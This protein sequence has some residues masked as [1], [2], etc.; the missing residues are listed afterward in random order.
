MPHDP[1]TCFEVEVCQLC[2]AYGDGYA[3]GKAKARMED[4][5]AIAHGAASG[6]GCG[7]SPCTALVEVLA[8]LGVLELPGRRGPG[9]AEARP[10]A[11]ERPPR[12]LPRPGG[13]VAALDMPS[14]WS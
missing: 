13:H 5:Q 12:R 8:E 1:A 9:R 7:C 11:P 10:G 3:A 4:A 14:C 6:H 2:D